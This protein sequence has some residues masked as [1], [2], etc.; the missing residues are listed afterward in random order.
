MGIVLGGQKPGAAS[1]TFT[2]DTAPFSLLTYREFQKWPRKIAI[3]TGQH[4][5]LPGYA[6]GMGAKV[7][8]AD[9]SGTLPDVV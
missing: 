7:Y 1:P 5:V 2:R 6:P 9:T 3:V 4:S 8:P